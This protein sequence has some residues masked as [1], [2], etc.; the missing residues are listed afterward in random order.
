MA[1]V[2]YASKY[3]QAVDER[4]KLGSLTAGIVNNNY[5]WLGVE[6]VTVY[7]VP[8]VAMGNY[9]ASGANRYG[10]PT[11]L[12]NEKQ[13]MK[14]AQDRAFTFTIDRKSYDDTMMTMEAGAALRRQRLHLQYARGSHRPEIRP[15]P[16]AAR[17]RRDLQFEQDGSC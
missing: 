3:A 4:F 1:T 10:S 17:E 12:G 7:S 8:T 9:T 14:V 13:E 2:N 16:C 6:T 11:E 15:C 5:D